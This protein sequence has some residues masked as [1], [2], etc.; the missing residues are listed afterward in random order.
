M[1]SEPLRTEVPKAADEKS[2]TSAAGPQVLPGNSATDRLNEV[3]VAYLR[4]EDAGQRVNRQQLLGQHPDLAAEL[5][6]FFQDHDELNHLAM[7][8]RTVPAD[9]LDTQPIDPAVTPLS[10]TLL[11]EP[12]AAVAAQP[13][14]GPDDT[15]ERTLPR[16]RLRYF[17]NYELLSEVARGGM[18]VVYKARQIRLN[19]IVAVKMILTGSL[20]SAQE[21]R[22]FRAEAE[23]AAQLQHPNI[24]AIHEIGEFNHHHF[25]SMDY[26]SGKSLATLLSQQQW[27]PRQ[28][29]ECVRIIAEA[30]Q[31]A[32]SKGVLHRDLKPSNVLMEELGTHQPALEKSTISRS[33]SVALH[34]QLL[35][36]KLTDF[37]LAKRALAG[38]SG[39]NEKPDSAQWL[40]SGAVVGTPSYMSPE[41]ASGKSGK[42]GPP[43]DVYSLGAILYELVT[44]RPPFRADAPMDT[45]M[46]VL[47]SEPAPPRSLNPVIP[48]DLET[49]CLKC[50]SKEPRQRYASAQQLA[51][52]LQR[53][54]HGEPILA[55]PLGWLERGWRWCLRNR[56]VAS[57]A[58]TVVFCL[59]A[60][61][62]GMTIAAVNLRSER[63]TA[64]QNLDRAI[65]A[66]S[67]ATDKLWDSYLAQARAERW[68]GRAGR[69][70]DS[71][72]AIAKAAAIKPSEEL[73][74]E[75]IASLALPDM[76]V[77]RR[78]KLNP[79]PP[80]AVTI[81]FDDRLERYATY[82]ASGTILVHRAADH[83]EL[84]RLPGPGNMVEWTL[85]FSPDGRWLVA[86][87]Q[88]GS[89]RLWDLMT[90]DATL[91]VPSGVSLG[92]VDFSPDSLR[93]AIGHNDGSIHLHATESGLELGRISSL[94][95]PYAIAFH[96]LKNKLAVSSHTSLQVVVVDAE[97]GDV[98]KSMPH[99]AGVRGMSWRGDGSQL[100]TACANGAV[101]V[102]DFPTGRTQTLDGHSAT[103]THVV[104]NHAGNMLA[105]Y[106]WDGATRLWEPHCKKL[107]VRVEGEFIA[108][109]GFG[110]DDRVLPFKVGADDVGLWEIAPADECR[111]FGR[112]VPSHFS[113]DGRWLA[114]TDEQGVRVW[115]VTT[116]C[117][118]LFIAQRDA[119]SAQFLDGD[120][121][122]LISA[123]NRLSLW[124][125]EPVSRASPET[126]V[127]GS[128]L[129]VTASA[130]PVL[131]PAHVTSD[132]RWLLTEQLGAHAPVLIDLQQRTHRT[133]EGQH[134]SRNL[135]L[136]ISPSA[137]WVA[138]G[139]WKGTGVKIWDAESGR[140]VADLLVEGNSNALFSP[141]EKWLVTG[142]GAEFR[143]WEVGSWQP[144]HS[145]ARDH[146][147]DIWGRMAF[148]PAGDLLAASIAREGGLQ[149]LDP[150][151]GQTLAM[152]T[153]PNQQTPACFSPDGQ[154][155]AVTAEGGIIQ[156]WN[157]AL[158]RERLSRM[159]LAWPSRSA[160][161]R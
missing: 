117:P 130:L 93:L 44:G 137:R 42:V 102:W 91:I 1:S 35:V 77:A 119:F 131:G 143:F 30:I 72:D 50:L 136:A 114:A 159:K 122:L 150:D 123:E 160:Q 107:H 109:S 47:N 21:V 79:A 37:G 14:Q 15:F 86:K 134:V 154:Q 46:Q 121:K 80:G 33:S 108:F 57:L 120:T 13:S 100:A 138:S 36:P 73:R 76:R 31:Y 3:L 5:E 158:V 141:D 43:S 78:W 32:H 96:P 69:R 152:L 116:G 54:I 127:A 53:F 142:C 112:G 18:G 20:A 82:D 61:S 156:V 58:A 146:A 95:Q 52:E 2:K 27:S 90:R 65:R 98:S 157:L 68:S 155:L 110:P 151:S 125:I 135:F 34:R 45:L 145:V 88:D 113:S 118:S 161:S 126:L 39:D 70:F 153:A 22:R 67:D 99:P 97:T 10:P 6:E 133:F 25:F 139:T 28:A 56:T 9:S 19:R 24:V 103:V 84:L 26:V 49:I 81:S 83:A 60:L 63:N 132:A 129:E 40:M 71:L 23:A 124:P 75:A 8:F 104:F 105:S 140:P 59:V 41:Q 66:E 55:R 149:L 4:A 48:T 74:H 92:A 89:L 101:L 16:P 29:A 85:R 115:N 38:S 64:L 12:D 94:A 87:Y 111:T 62:I 148:A 7:P 11:F 51:D 106:G 147:G 144:R 128:R 17:G